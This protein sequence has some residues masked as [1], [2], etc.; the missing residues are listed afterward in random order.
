MNTNQKKND[1]W[2][3]TTKNM[4][5]ENV[6]AFDKSRDMNFFALSTNGV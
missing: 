3:N 5:S 6:S 2:N 4:L 1:C